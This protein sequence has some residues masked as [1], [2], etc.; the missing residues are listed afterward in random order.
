MKKILRIAQREFLATVKTAGFLVGILVA[1]A[2]MVV[3]LLVMPRLMT[4]PA[5]RVEGQVAIVDSTGAVADGLRAYLAPEAMAARRGEIARQIDRHMPSALR[6]GAPLPLD[7]ILGRVPKLE[8]VALPF[9]ADL[10][11]EKEPL[12]QDEGKGGG[13]LMLLVIDT[14]AVT[15]TPGS[16][17]YG[18][19]DL[20]ARGKLDDRL[21]E[22]V[23][24][25]LREAIVT[26]RV[27]AAGLDRQRIEAVTRVARRASVTVTKE[28]DRQTNKV[29]N[30]LLAGGFMFL[31]MTSV[32]VGGQNL[33]T[34][35]VEEKSNR[36]IEILL[37]AV[38]PMQL[39]TG[40]ILGHLAVGLVV[41]LLYG[42]MGIVALVSFSLMGLLDATLIVYLIIF[43]LISYFVVAAFMAAVGA[44]VNEMREAQTLMMPVMLLLMIP[45]VLW[46]PISRDPNGALAVTLSF[47]PPTNS[48]AMLL[49]LTSA[50]PPAAWQ[51][52]L[53]IAIGLASV[54][55]A[56][57]AAAKVFRIGLLLY[58]KPPNLATLVRWIR[59]A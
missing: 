32:M 7:A 51:A 14:N 11:R 5:P 49:R 15:P 40:K 10:E 43:F 17:E 20:F 16:N 29:F 46:M 48:V 4:N 13:R 42:G 55:A 53:S 25:G 57:W 6:A 56:L 37:S 33:L 31:L 24:S 1:P 36:V 22:E 30:M 47:L 19:Y 59:M 27:R 44:A 23:A 45:G 41:L 18:S 58:G 3:L 54:Y 21:E 12:R 39:M 35:T 38:S 9:N 26:A 52:W 2:L 8:I 34:T 28:G 50:T